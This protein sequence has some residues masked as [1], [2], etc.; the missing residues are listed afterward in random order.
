MNVFVFWACSSKFPLIF[1]DNT[2]M[3]YLFCWEIS[4][5]LDI[6]IGDKLILTVVVLCRL[7][8]RTLTAIRETLWRIIL[9]VVYFVL[10]S[11]ERFSYF[12]LSRLASFA[13]V[14]SE[15]LFV[16]YDDEDVCVW[17]LFHRKETSIKRRTVNISLLI[18][19][20]VMSVSL[21]VHCDH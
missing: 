5:D 6:P 9:R 19:I 11:S 10:C 20:L 4:G 13:W 2:E 17:N 21:F 8:A 16:L 14:R 18:M 3:C 1:G 7:M 15:M 12:F